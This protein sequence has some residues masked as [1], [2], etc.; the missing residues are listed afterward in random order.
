MISDHDVGYG[1]NRG[2]IIRIY[3][4]IGLYWRDSFLNKK[5]AFYVSNDLIF[6]A[7]HYDKRLHKGDFYT[8][9]DHPMLEELRLIAS[10]ILSVDR[11]DGA[12][13][14]YPM[15]CYFCIEDQPDLSSMDT[16]SSLK[17][18]LESKVKT[19][20]VKWR[21]SLLPPIFGGEN[22]Q[23]RPEKT[24]AKHQQAIYRSLTLKRHLL[25]RGIRALTKATMLSCHRELYEAPHWATY[26]AKEASFQEIL[27][28]LR[29]KGMANPSKYDA[30][31][32][33]EDA[34]GEPRSGKTY[35]EDY[36]IAR[37]STLHPYSN[38][39]G[40]DPYPPIHHDDFYNLYV[41]LK[42]IY[43][44]LILRKHIPINL[45]YVS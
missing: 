42:V 37:N 21:D 5:A 11:F 2:T 40:V 9:F 4:P 26:I 39:F 15:D 28:V 20:N 36:R 34:F 8:E 25:F 10:Q 22:Y 24:P 7:C 44:W 45:E 14:P 29:D 31:A 23:F 41:D 17:E 19:S 1:I 12:I 32:Y 38:E 27:H 43:R 3:S 33:M 13:T 18:S 6:S 16:L 30:A 35:F